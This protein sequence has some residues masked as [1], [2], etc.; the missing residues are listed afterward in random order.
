MKNFFFLRFDAFY[1]ARSRFKAL[2]VR[3]GDASATSG[4][5]SE[6]GDDHNAECLE[7]PNADPSKANFAGQCQPG[8]EG[9][10][11]FRTGNSIDLISGL[12]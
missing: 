7:M 1:Q 2:S 10:F 9:N 3:V 4:A 12:E 11:L 6:L 5:P 8:K